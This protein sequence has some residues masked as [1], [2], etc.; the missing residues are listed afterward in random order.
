MLSLVPGYR[1]S[2]RY[3]LALESAA[4][5]YPRF[6]ACH[7]FDNKDYPIDVVK[8]VTATEWS[9]KILGAAKKFEG[10]LWEEIGTAGKTGEKL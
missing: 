10:D 1:R 7:E 5:G 9:K 3:E 6:L 8:L 4:L 2:T